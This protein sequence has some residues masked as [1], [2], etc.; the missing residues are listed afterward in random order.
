MRLLDDLQAGLAAIDA[1]HL[2]RVRRTA[3]SPTDRS[4]RIDVPGGEPRD[5]LGFCGN[6][7]LGLAAHPALAQAVSEGAR[8]YGVGSGASHLVS[9]HSVAHARL[10]ARM[11]ALQAPHIPTPMRCSSAPAIWPTWR[12]SARWRRPAASSRR[13]TARSS[14]MR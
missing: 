6:D 3:H 13:T 11:A 5:V 8:R 2:R 7:Y 1:A 10:E 9:G 12:W 14:P 4:Q